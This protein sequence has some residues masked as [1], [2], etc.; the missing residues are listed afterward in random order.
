MKNLY[1]N[2]DP[3][4]APGVGNLYSAKCGGERV[5]LAK[6]KKGEGPNEGI[7]YTYILS[8]ETGEQGVNEDQPAR[9]MKC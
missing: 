7:I 8:L 1:R 2:F 9:S 3:F 5:D 6:Y 4:K